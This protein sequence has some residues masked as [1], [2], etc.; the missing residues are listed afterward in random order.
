[1]PAHGK[2][3]TALGIELHGFFRKMIF[4]GT[5]DPWA[6]IRTKRFKRRLKEAD[7]MGFSGNFGQSSATPC[8]P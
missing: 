6:G 1:V 2:H 4:T 7:L 3:K 8:R 5:S